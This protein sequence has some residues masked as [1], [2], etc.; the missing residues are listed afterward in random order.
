[1]LETGK[2]VEFTAARADN[3]VLRMTPIFRKQEARE[4]VKLF[5]AA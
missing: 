3:N 5:L 2:F 4:K 1:V